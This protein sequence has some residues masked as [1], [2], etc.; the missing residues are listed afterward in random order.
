MKAAISATY[1]ALSFAI[2]LLSSDNYKSALGQAQQQ[3]QNYKNPTLGISIQYPPDWQID[4]KRPNDIN[5]Y[6]QKGIVYVSVGSDDLDSS[7]SSSSQATATPNAQLSEYVSSQIS[8]RIEDKEDF[9]LLESGPVTI[10]GDRLAHRALYT[11]VKGEEEINPGE[12]NKVIRIWTI[13]GDKAYD[14]AYVAESNLFDRYLPIF[15]RTDNN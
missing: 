10:S 14:I 1:V 7:S 9:A 5:I 11:F 3:F 12:I 2:L 13:I 4:E 6:K 8:K 15:Q